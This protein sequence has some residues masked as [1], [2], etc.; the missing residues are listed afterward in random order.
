MQK[1]QAIYLLEDP[2]KLTGKNYAT[3]L[4]LVME[5]GDQYAHLSTDPIATF[6]KLDLFPT[7][8]ADVKEKTIPVLPG[9]TS[10]ITEES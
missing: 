9:Q 4:L 5:N 3:G 2:T 7:K 6:E 1:V 10:L 8:P